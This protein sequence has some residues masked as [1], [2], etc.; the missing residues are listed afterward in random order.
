MVK[1][2][3]DVREDPLAYV[4]ALAVKAILSYNSVVFINRTIW[5]FIFK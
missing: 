2:N 3:G 5:L 1:L 4:S